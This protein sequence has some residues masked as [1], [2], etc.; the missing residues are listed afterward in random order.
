M[1]QRVRAADRKA[2]AR[3]EA[4]EQ[5]KVTTE[6]RIS[7]LEQDKARLQAQIRDTEKAQDQMIGRLRYVREQLGEVPPM[8]PVPDLPE[9]VVEEPS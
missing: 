9:S 7:F 1:T 4:L 5:E 8:V 2:D 3:R 6:A